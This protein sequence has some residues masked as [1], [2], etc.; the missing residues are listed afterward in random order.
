MNK[1][2]ILAAAALGLS[3]CNSDEDYLGAFESDPNAVHFS[4]QIAGENQATLDTK[5]VG[6]TTAFAENAKIAVTAGTQDEVNYI[7]K[8]EAWN[9]EPEDKYLLWE[10][11]TG[12][13]FNAY[14]PVGV[15]DASLTTFTLPDE[16]KTAEALE[17]A[18][19]MTAT[20][21]ANKADGTV[22]LTMEHKM[23]RAII[24]VTNINNQYTDKFKVTSIKMHVNYNAYQGG[25]RVSGVK[26]V[27]MLPQDQNKTF[28]A[29]VVPTDAADGTFLTISGADNDGQ[30]ETQTLTVKGIPAMAAGSSYTFKL[31]VGKVEAKVA[32]VTVKSWT[33]GEVLAKGEEAEEVTITYPYAVAKTHTIYTNAEG[34][35]TTDLITKAL[36]GGTEVAVN[37][38]FSADDYTL[39]G[40]NVETLDLSQLTVTT[41]PEWAFY[42]CTKLA[43]IT[44]P[45][46]VTSIPCGAFHSCGA[47]T[48]ITLPTSVTSISGS[49]FNGC[50]KLESI[51]LPTSVTSIGDHAFDECGLTKITLPSTVTSIPESA[52]Y[53]CA[54]LGEV[55]CEGNLSSVGK[56]AFYNCVKL[57]KVTF[58]GD[59]TAIGPDAFGQ[60]A[61]LT[62]VDLSASSNF[63]SVSEA[64]EGMNTFQG[65]TVTI[66]VK[67]TA[68]KTQYENDKNWKN[69]RNADNTKITF[70]QVAYADA[71]THT[72]YTF[73]NGQLTEALI[74]EAVGSGI[75]PKLIINGPISSVDFSTTLVYSEVTFKT[76]DLSDAT[77]DAECLAN[78]NFNMNAIANVETL[79]LSKS[80]TTVT[81]DMGFSSTLKTLTLPSSITSIGDNAFPACTSLTKVTCKGVLTEI[82]EKAFNKCSELSDLDLSA[83]SYTTAPTIGGD[84]TELFN[85]CEN[86]EVTVKDDASRQ[87]FMYNN[88]WKILRLNKG[89]S[90][91]YEE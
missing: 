39:L 67:T 21:T 37:G 7:L 26:E 60:C 56:T 20:T 14:Y 23:A 35:V 59:V 63:T 86:V 5:A 66:Y 11:A 31:T 27:E 19:Y 80:M 91:T 24:K 78:L 68:L 62:T 28:Y 74:R 77:M 84:E 10:K 47:L 73:A 54:N 2:Y 46:T 64:S 58:K 15:N 90:I 52:F 22:A 55:T 33:D 36:D 12:L 8:S 6:E 3:A 83:V 45:S 57:T 25:E 69:A 30:G 75:F 34:Q 65:A 61:K 71:T 53:N 72:V 40:N 18:N 87:A 13:E 17:N 82:G 41:L 44:L 1:L 51:T 32:N 42:Q 89:L 29:L 16:Y 49:A 81:N 85:S 48:T 9:P 70:V 4:V 79:T 43:T 50:K 76:L 88:K 38:V